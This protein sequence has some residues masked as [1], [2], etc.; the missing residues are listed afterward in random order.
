MRARHSSPRRLAGKRRRMKSWEARDARKAQAGQRR[1]GR[2]AEQDLQWPVAGTPERKAA[3]TERTA[4]RA[5]KGRPRVAGKSKKRG[6]RRN[7][8]WS[9]GKATKSRKF[10]KTCERNRPAA[11]KAQTVHLNKAYGGQVPVVRSAPVTK[12]AKPLCPNAACRSQA[13]SASD[14]CCWRCGWAY[15]AGHAAAAQKS[16]ETWQAGIPGTP[17]RLEA[18]TRDLSDSQMYSPANRE[19]LLAE[20]QKARQ[21]RGQEDAHTA[22]MIVKSRGARSLAEAY[23]METDPRAQE[24]L[25]SVLSGGR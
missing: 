21:A 25:R 4:K 11:V 9:C 14:K 1:A 23:R 8:C 16:A 12:A 22:A 19:A 18:K 13:S 24:I 17:E 2:R 15:S 5:R 7:L 10:C 20:A 3:A 6:A